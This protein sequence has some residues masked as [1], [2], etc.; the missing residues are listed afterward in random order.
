MVFCCC[1]GV[2][3]GCWGVGGFVE[4]GVVGVGVVVGVVCMCCFV[5]FGMGVD[6]GMVDVLVLFF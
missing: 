3:V 2:V 1:V 5:N 6:G 4:V